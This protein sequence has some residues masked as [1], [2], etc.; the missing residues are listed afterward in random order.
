MDREQ[1][2]KKIEKYAQAASLAPSTVCQYA[3]RNRKVYA[4]LKAGGTC[5]V[6]SI[7]A[8]LHWMAENPV[9]GGAAE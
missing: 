3:L 7:E 6:A 9:K 8:L 1:I 5:S 4:R 2:I